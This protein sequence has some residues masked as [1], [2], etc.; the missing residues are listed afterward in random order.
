LSQT[1]S[2]S[3]RDREVY[4]S[5]IP[6]LISTEDL[7]T[8]IADA[9]A[10]KY[11]TIERRLSA[12][13]FHL[14]QTSLSLHRQETEKEKE[15]EMERER[16]FRDSLPVS[17]RALVQAHRFL[18]VMSAAHIISDPAEYD[19]LLNQTEKETET[20]KEREKEI[21]ARLEGE[22]LHSPVLGS[23]TNQQGEREIANILKLIP[24]YN[25]FL[26]SLSLSLSPS[27]SDSVQTEEEVPS[28]CDI[29]RIDLSVS[30]SS[31][32]VDQF[33]H[34]YIRLNKPV[35]LKLPSQV[36]NEDEIEREWSRSAMLKQE[37]QDVEVRDVSF[38]LLMSHS[39]Y[40]SL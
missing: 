35:L 27:P 37:K 19:L 28:M 4:L 39:C 2:L 8:H 40:L 6:A 30:L 25:D 7:L 15:M 26:P 16:L 18:H 33:Y 10:L 13:L 20:E 5:L 14:V 21:R 38:C 34:D 12:A 36:W 9:H 11:E 3:P 31:F 24:L 32:H 23:P 22:V 1:S 29:D 17:V